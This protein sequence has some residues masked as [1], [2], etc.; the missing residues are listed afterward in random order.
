M[1]YLIGVD[2]AGRGPLAGPVSVAA[3]LV[4]ATLDIKKAFPDV[5]DSKL[6]SAAKRSEIFNEVS[7]RAKAGELKYRVRFSDH[8]Y[9]DEYGIARAVRRAVA[10]CVCSVSPATEGVRVF[11]DGLLYA[12]S[13]YKQETII[14][15]DELVPVISLASVIAKV[16]RDT[17]MMRFSKRF[18]QYGFDSHKGYGTKKHWAA[19]REF[20]MCEIHRTSYCKKYF[21]QSA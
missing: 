8:L 14:N 1:E 13:K 9:I 17:I 4:P 6:L 5:K 7:A 3:V 19:L 18:P 11:L 10:Q 12:P 16:Q 20:G 21:L 15:G 2:E